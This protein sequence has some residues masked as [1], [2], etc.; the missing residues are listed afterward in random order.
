MNDTVISEVRNGSDGEKNV[1]FERKRMHSHIEYKSIMAHDRLVSNK[2]LG[3]FPI[4]RMSCLQ[5]KSNNSLEMH[6]N[7]LLGT[8]NDVMTFRIYI[9]LK[10]FKC[11]FINMT[12]YLLAFLS[13]S[14]NQNSEQDSF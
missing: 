11:G 14:A 5:E 1:I 8:P 12:S 6:R 9:K 3:K 13:N 10:Y 4:E 7:G 2:Q